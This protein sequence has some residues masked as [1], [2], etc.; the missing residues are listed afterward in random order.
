MVT[1]ST[2][3]PNFTVPPASVRIGIVYGSHSAI[4]SPAF[5]LEPSA[6]LSLAP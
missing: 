2:M 1:P 5:T 4:I 6:F 3:S